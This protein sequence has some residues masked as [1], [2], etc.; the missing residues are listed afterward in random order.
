[1]PQPKERHAARHRVG[2]IVALLLGAATGLG[3]MVDSLGRSS[4]T[5]DEVMYLEVAARWW[6][7]GEQERITRAGSPLTFW[8]LQQVPM[9]WVL[10]RLGYGAWID[11]P[12]SHEAA[13][14]PIARLSALWVWLA[15]L[16]LTAAWSRRLYGPRAMVLAAWW[17]ALS[18]NLLAHGCLITMELPIVAS[19]TGM[20]LCFWS[21]LRTGDRRAFL[22]SAILGGLAFSCKFTAVVVLPIFGL[23]WCLSRWAAG[24]RRPDRIVATVAL[25][26]TGFLAVMA[27]ANVAI[28]GGA[29]LPIS[30]QTGA[31][32]TF[33]GKFGP[34]VQRWLRSLIE[35]PFPQDWVGFLRQTILQR[36]GAPSYLF[37]ELRETGWSYYYLVALAVKVPLTFWLVLAARAAVAGGIPSAGRAWV[38]PAAAAA[39]VT[40]ASVASTRNFGLRYLLPIAPMAIVWI[41][42]LAEGKRWARRLAWGGLAAQAIAVAS[43]HPYELSYFNVLAGGP[44]GGRRILSDSNLDWGQ[45]LKLLAGLQRRRPEFRNLTLFYFGDTEPARYG[46]AGRC[47]AVRA[48]P[49]AT[50]RLPRQ[51]APETPY[52]A[53]SAS[54]QQGPWGPAGFFRA[55]DGL[56][57]VCFTE[58]TT[59]AIY[60]TAEIPGL[61]SGEDALARAQRPENV[62]G[63][64]GTSSAGGSTGQSS[65]GKSC[66]I[67]RE[68]FHRRERRERREKDRGFREFAPIPTARRDRGGDHRTGVRGWDGTT[69][70]PPR[71]SARSHPRIART[72]AVGGPPAPS[73]P[74]SDERGHGGDHR[75][76]SGFLSVSLCGLCGLRGESL[77]ARA[78]RTFL[79]AEKPGLPV[80]QP[81]RLRPS[82]RTRT[83]GGATIRA[84][85]PGAP[86]GGEPLNPG[87][88]SGPRRRQSGCPAIRRGS[89]PAPSARPPMGERGRSGSARSSGSARCRRHRLVTSRKSPPGH[90]CSTLGRRRHPPR[91]SSPSRSRWGS[92]PRTGRPRR[93]PRRRWPAR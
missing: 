41:S 4:A 61:R 7:T 1:D 36:S 23:L 67:D 49:G 28:T 13:L 21:F 17:F 70:L 25:G 38:L 5:Y 93:R 65:S 3:L 39:F 32:P 48:T 80:R 69:V 82:P 2:P 60:R 9:L 84:G 22:A 20:G 89:S 11:D 92:H 10:D 43:I 42:G 71:A 27:L 53:V 58:D 74:R 83:P 90:S 66:P 57:P 26:M 40:L 34:A 64:P 72:R 6:R 8:K 85:R 78:C 24:D 59:I 76:V 29:L 19:M 31:H 87:R 63:K 50:A 30:Q 54:L 33:D 79:G 45:G 56:D 77:G 86:C 88:W 16:A 44:I 68:V 55:L 62:L 52:L 81:L 73:E 12:A 37:G 47:Y 18:P 75:D 15:A 35:A 46:V 14:L 91:S 51:L